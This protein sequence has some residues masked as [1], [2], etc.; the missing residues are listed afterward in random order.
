MSAA[1][2]DRSR[3]NRVRKQKIARRMRDREM[4]KGI[5]KQRK[6]PTELSGTAP[7]ASIA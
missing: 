1:N 5:F 6:S 2:G 4:I 7:K 3:F